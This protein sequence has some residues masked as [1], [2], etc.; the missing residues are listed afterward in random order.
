MKILIVEDDADSGEALTYFLSERGHDVRLVP[1]SS[2]ALSAALEFLPDVAL[3]DI[4]LPVVSG[5]DLVSLMR[6]LPELAGCRY[7]A[8]TAYAGAHWAQ[9]S[10]DA[11][12]EHHLTKPLQISRLLQFLETAQRP[13]AIAV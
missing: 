10:S 3:L 7:L 8:T 12:F 2:L 6:G 1:S 11:G 4:G 5:Y 13:A 9:R